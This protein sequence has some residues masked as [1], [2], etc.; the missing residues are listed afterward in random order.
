MSKH[1]IINP[2]EVLNFG[3]V[4][5]E[6]RLLLDSKM[7]GEPCINVN[8]CTIPRG[9][10]SGVPDKTTGKPVGAAHEKPEIYVCISGH[11]D[12]WLD[13]EKIDFTPG[14]LAYIRG[15]VRHYVKNLSETETVCFLTFWPNEQDNDT[16]V[17][18]KKAWGEGYETRKMPKE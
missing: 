10:C 6:S 7:A 17:N 16:W 18:R 13:D 14:T 4:F 3:K 8:H 5:C 11:G 1:L 15:G 2:D 12:L 9:G